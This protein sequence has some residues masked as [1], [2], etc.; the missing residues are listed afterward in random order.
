MESPT[1]KV[2][3]PVELRKMKKSMEKKSQNM[4]L[5]S[6]KLKEKMYSLRSTTQ[7]GRQR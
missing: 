3:T 7:R 6:Q 5:N 4:K 2:Q 1:H